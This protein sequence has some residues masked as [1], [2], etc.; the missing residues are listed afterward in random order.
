MMLRDI[1]KYTIIYVIYVCVNQLNFSRLFEKWG[2]ESLN[3]GNT[4]LYR[5]FQ[6]IRNICVSKNV[7]KPPPY[8]PSSKETTYPHPRYKTKLK[9]TGFMIVP[10]QTMHYSI[11]MGNP[12]NLPY[13]CIKFDPPPQEV[14]K[15]A[16]GPPSLSEPVG[17]IPK[18]TA[19]KKA[20]IGPTQ[21]K[22][23]TYPD[24][25]RIINIQSHRIYPF[26][27]ELKEAPCF[28]RP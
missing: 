12:S 18:R 28:F 21:W 20:W 13:I 25:S 7:S 15:K 16:A 11:L 14:L 3:P 6:P 22:K 2:G 26:Q 8:I 4:L 9:M 1:H 27:T 10:F 19:S 5:W 23:R 17:K 24:I